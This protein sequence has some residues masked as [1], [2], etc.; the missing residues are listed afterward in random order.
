MEKEIA[1]W[2]K[3]VKESTQT[4]TEAMAQVWTSWLALM[5][6]ETVPNTNGEKPASE[7]SEQR[8]HT[9]DS[10]TPAAEK[11]EVRSHTS[12]SP[13]VESSEAHSVHT[14]SVHTLEISINRSAKAAPA[15][16]SAPLKQQLEAKERTIKELQDRLAVEQ[17]LAKERAESYEALQQQLEGK[18]RDI[19]YLQNQ[20][21]FERKLA[22]E[23]AE[24]YGNL[25][26]QLEQQTQLIV[27]LERQVTEL[28]SSSAI[29][30]WQLNK[31]R[32]RSFS[33]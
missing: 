2:N 4:W 3:T 24:S 8:A 15:A 21:A 18:D 25:Q 23:R 14:S 30:S 27:K 22:R 11:Y 31:W 10:P 28:Q 9:I 33:G 29:A 1:S 12:D 20:L 32:Y 16:E 26:Q 5:G 17:K 6:F 13:T 7:K 19:S